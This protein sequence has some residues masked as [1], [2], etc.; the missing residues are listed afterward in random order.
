MKNR[1]ILVTGGNPGIGLAIVKG[2]A[3]NP[4]NTVLLG[5]RNLA[6]CTSEARKLGANVEAVHLNLAEKVQFAQNIGTLKQTYS[7]VD[8][9]INNAGVLNQ[10]SFLSVPFE[11]LDETLRVNTL[12]PYEL[13]RAF[14]P[15]MIE[16]GYGRVVNVSSGWVAFNEGLA[17]PFC[18]SFTKAALNALTLTLAKE[19][20]KHVKVNSMCPG[21]VRTRMGGMQATR[22]PEQ[23]AETALWLANLPEE[24]PSGGFYRDK[25]RIEW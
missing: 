23:G 20:P 8:V 6:D 9:L 4:K 19:L 21:W 1:I 12:G 22:S 14:V 3:R 13:L 24:G 7:R 5:C 18:Y 15:G 2:L 25:Q 11:K 10:G 17:G 16:N